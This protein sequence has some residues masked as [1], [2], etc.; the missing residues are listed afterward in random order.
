MLKYIPVIKKYIK[1]VIKALLNYTSDNSIYTEIHTILNFFHSTDNLTIVDIGAHNGDFIGYFEK[2][3]KINEAFLFE[4]IPECIANLQKRFPHYQIYPLAVSNCEGVTQFNLNDNLETSSILDFNETSDLDNVSV[5]KKTSIPV[6]TDKL[7]NILELQTKQIDILKIDVQGLE[8]LV[9]QGGIET[10]KRIKLIYVEVSFSKLYVGS[11]D[12][13][14]IFDLLN[15]NDFR[16][17]EIFPAHRSSK[18]IL[19]QGNAIFFNNN[20]LINGRGNF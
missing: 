16:L 15:K 18:G 10:L 2:V 14:E 4:P 6:K 20:N 17:F 19:L 12:F 7:D 8:H 9:I 13:F 5:S 3:Y 11:S 1:G